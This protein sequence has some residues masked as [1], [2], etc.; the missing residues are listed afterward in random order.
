M[1]RTFNGHTLVS[2]KRLTLDFKRHSAWRKHIECVAHIEFVALSDYCGCVV[3]KLFAQRNIVIMTD[4]S[5][6]AGNL[7]RFSAKIETRVVLTVAD[8][9]KLFPYPRF[10]NITVTLC[11]IIVNSVTV[12]VCCNSCIISRL[13]SALNFKA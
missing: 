3:N 2:C 12:S 1:R 6:V 10:E 13:C 7:T 4:I 11:K 9:F 5:A 8:F